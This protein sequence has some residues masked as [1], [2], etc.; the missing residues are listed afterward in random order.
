MAGGVNIDRELVA[1]GAR[2]KAG[3]GPQSSLP[4]AAL[5]VNDGVDVTTTTLVRRP[6]V[7]GPDRRHDKQ[8]PSSP[9]DLISD[10]R[11]HGPCW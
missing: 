9:A 11:A 6:V 2:F 8:Q 10:T 3:G 1:R 5:T 7:C 4:L